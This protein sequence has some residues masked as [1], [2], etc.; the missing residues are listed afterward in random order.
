MRFTG[1]LITQQRSDLSKVDWLLLSCSFKCSSSHSFIILIRFNLPVSGGSFY[2]TTADRISSST[3]LAKVLWL[4]IKIF[5]CS[6][7]FWEG[8]WSVL[9]IAVQFVA[10]KLFQKCNWVDNYVAIETISTKKVCTFFIINIKHEKFNLLIGKFVSVLNCYR[11]WFIKQKKG[12]V[13]VRVRV[14][15]KVVVKNLIKIGSEI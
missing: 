2:F 15:R 6:L 14:T 4:N 13:G 10:H 11:S 7:L 3:S 8:I 12:K 1:F 9:C 5:W